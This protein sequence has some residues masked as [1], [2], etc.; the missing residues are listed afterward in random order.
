MHR[1]FKSFIFD[2]KINIE[3]RDPFT[4]NFYLDSRRPKKS[5]KYSVR[6]NVFDRQKRQRRFYVTKWE[7]TE[8][9][10]SSIW[11]TTKPRYNALETRREMDALLL[12]AE[13]AAAHLE[14][15]TFEAFE[16]RLYINPGENQNLTYHY[17]NIIDANYKQGR[18]AN[19]E[20]YER[21]LN[22]LNS[23]IE[24][25]YPQRQRELNLNEITC[26]WLEEYEDWMLKEKKSPT[27]IGFYLRSLRSVFNTAIGSGDLLPQAYPFGKGK[28][29]MT[30]VRKV[31]K[32]LT[33][34]QLRALWESTPA[35]PE[36][37]QARD[38]FFLS[39]LLSGMNVRDIAALRWKNIDGDQI[40]Y[41]RHKTLNTGKANR[42]EISVIMPP[43]A[44]KIVKKWGTRKGS[45]EKLVFDIIH[46]NDDEITAFRKVKNY[47]RFLNQA[48]KKLAKSNKL[49]GELSTYWARH[50]FA[51][52]TIQAGA[53]MEY[54]SEALNHSSMKTT[55]NYFSGFEIETKRKFA[56]KLM[57]F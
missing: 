7:F 47:T 50:S 40:R 32:A 4:I 54:V 46:Q 5:G 26:S 39:Y 14:P 11:E 15:F 38:M 30:N 42:K 31:H 2:G 9:E 12:S 45:P 56:K 13:N 19:A 21:S 16:K 52:I 10:Y 41:F 28:Y 43:E 22:S 1:N 20:S 17:K 23:Y 29:Q 24:Y 6:L 36:Q 33:K 35:T 48:L 37:R 34:D 55:Q 53:S 51:S 3:M 49:P 8:Q 27:T 25:K 44:V 57:T 18:P